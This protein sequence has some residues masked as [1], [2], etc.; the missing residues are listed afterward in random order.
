ML[1][2]KKTLSKIVNWIKSP[3]INWANETNGGRTFIVKNT[4]GD[5]I[6]FGYS[7]NNTDYGLWS[8]KLGKWLIHGDENKVYVNG[9]I[10]FNVNAVLWSG[11][12]YMGEIS[13][14]VQ[15]A[16]LSQNITDQTNGVV[17]CWSGYANGA[18]QNYDWAYTFIPKKHVQSHINAGVCTFLNTQ[19][20][21]TVGAK[22]VYVGNNKISGHAGNTATG[23]GASG[24]KYTNNHWVLR[25]VV[26][27]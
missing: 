8:T 22:Y 4:N 14:T 15:T 16:D 9:G 19:T 3:I 10:P 21:G 23:T 5:S 24:I 20:F 11:A 18:A 27:V 6:N 25:Y 2:V 26:G 17:L 1:D 12:S 13:G 7:A